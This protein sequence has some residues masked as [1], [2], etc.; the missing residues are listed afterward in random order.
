MHEMTPRQRL[1]AAIKGEEVDR[2]PFSPFLAYYFESLPAEVI[3]KGQ[4]QYLEEMGADPLL[5]GFSCPHSIHNRRCDVTEQVSGNKKTKTIST[6]YGNLFAE[7]TYLEDA[8]TWFLTRH[9]VETLEDIQRLKAYFEDLQVVNQVNRVND[10]VQ[11]IGERALVLPIIGIDAKSSFQSLLEY[12]V[13][14]ENLIY[15]CMDDPDE[16]DDLL[17]LMREKAKDAVRLAAECNIQA[18]ISW[19]DSSTT[20][21]SPQMYSQYIAPE[22]TDWVQILQ[23]NHITYVQHAC[24]LIKD[25]LDPIAQQGVTCIESITPFPTGNIDMLQAFE[26]LPPSVSLIGGIDATMMLNG[27][28]EELENHVLQLLQRK[29]KRGFVLANSD[30][31]PPGVAYE[32]FLHLAKLVQMTKI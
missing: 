31:C 1:L 3:Q 17:F 32:K 11:E 7:Y 4:L 2:T 6:P 24:G 22:L 26:A 28:L 14:T 19:E 30:S 12:W 10:Y 13:G 8:K 29:G 25:L 20:N 5:R 16:I 15:M 9:P 27:S 18:C 23:E 21:V